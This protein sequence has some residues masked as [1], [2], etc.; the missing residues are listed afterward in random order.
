MHWKI[1]AAMPPSPRR[2]IYC[3]TN[4]R[5]RNCAFINWPFCYYRIKNMYTIHK[6]NIIIA[7]H[8]KH[9]NMGTNKNFHLWCFT[10]SIANGIK[11]I[12]QNVIAIRS[13]NIK[14]S[15]LQ[16]KQNNPSHFPLVKRLTRSFQKNKNRARHTTLPIKSK[17]F[18]IN[19]ILHWRSDLVHLFQT[20]L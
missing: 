13:I 1:R 15:W 11:I 14:Q 3:E 5:Y 16:I 2:R 4:P 7:N 17:Y 19:C 8:K 10:V 18:F 9:A 20:I 12:A 6:C